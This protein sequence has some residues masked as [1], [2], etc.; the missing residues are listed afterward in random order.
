MG[1]IRF[2]KALVVF[3]IIVL[4]VVLLPF[5]IEKCEGLC[6][7]F[8]L[9]VSALIFNDFDDHIR[10]DEEGGDCMGFL[11]NT[12]VDVEDLVCDLGNCQW[13][14]GIYQGTCKGA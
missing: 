14:Q 2:D 7:V 4:P 1:N 8:L 10:H 11:N 9:V 12:H 5:L 3:K 13:D 6:L